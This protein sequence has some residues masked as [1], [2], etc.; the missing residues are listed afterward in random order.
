MALGGGLRLVLMGAALGVAGVLAL[1]RLTTSVLYGVTP[2]DPLTIVAAVLLLVGVTLLACW[3][4][5]L[6]AARV[7]PAVALRCE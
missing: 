6:R 3:L 1:T 5:A 2:S 4:P 7:D